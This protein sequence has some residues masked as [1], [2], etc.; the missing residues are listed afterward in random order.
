[1]GESLTRRWNAVRE[2]R[3]QWAV[4]FNLL[5]RVMGRMAGTCARR[6]E[7]ENWQGPAT[8]DLVADAN[9][10]HLAGSSSM[11]LH[12]QLAETFQ[13]Q[14]DRFQT[15]DQSS[16]AEKRARALSILAKTLESIAAI[17][18]K[19]DTH[20]NQGAGL[21]NGQSGGSLSG[22]Q[23]SD[24]QELD[25]QLTALIANLVRDGE[26]TNSFGNGGAAEGASA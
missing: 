13:E 10:Q 8:A 24:T 17:G 26:N 19:L 25:R 22:S 21:E 23:A 14:L 9:C 12:R 1:M 3:E 2:L 6:A 11:G 7:K 15:E 16:D 18:T 4:P 5:D 20:A